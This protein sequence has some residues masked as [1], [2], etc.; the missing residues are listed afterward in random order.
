M[1]II[2]LGN[3]DIHFTLV[4]CCAYTQFRKKALFSEVTAGRGILFLSKF[5]TDLF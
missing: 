2:A 5:R 1:V 4:V 3:D